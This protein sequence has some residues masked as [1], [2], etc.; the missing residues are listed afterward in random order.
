MTRLA[1]VV[2]LAALGMAGFAAPASATTPAVDVAVSVHTGAIALDDVALIAPAA[3]TETEGL[4]VIDAATID[5]QP[6]DVYVDRPGRLHRSTLRADLVP[7]PEAPG[8]DTDVIGGIEFATGRTF[9]LGWFALV[10]SGEKFTDC[11]VG[12]FLLSLDS[13]EEGGVPYDAATG[14]ATVVSTDMFTMPGALGC[15]GYEP[16]VNAFFGLP[17]LPGVASVALTFTATPPFGGPAA[18]ASPATTTTTTTTTTSTPPP[19]DTTGPPPSSA[20]SATTPTAHPEV[21]TSSTYAPT[22]SPAPAA[23]SSTP[24]RAEP[25]RPSTS[26]AATGAP[27]T[28]AGP[29][30]TT[31]PDGYFAADAFSGGPGAGS[32]AVPDDA[33]PAGGELRGARGRRPNVEPIVDAASG[34]APTKVMVIVVLVALVSV[35]FALVRSE[36][37]ASAWAKRR[38]YSRAR[39]AF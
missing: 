31:L 39:R 25:A 3:A 24:R 4:F 7:A 23:R 38:R 14:T 22:D 9:V 27:E 17:S 35:A 13:A 15:A 26:A 8:L 10:I 30:T 1:S 32:A 19:T 21:Q 37:G 18:P 16:E 6:R 36:V 2:A 20:G 29:T 34:S 12:P 11:R 33:T 28:T 5:F